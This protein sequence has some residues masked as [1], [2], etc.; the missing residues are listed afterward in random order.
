ME[1]MIHIL[2][3][4]GENGVDINVKILDQDGIYNQYSISCNNSKSGSWITSNYNYLH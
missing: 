4:C 2:Q 3:Q 1:I